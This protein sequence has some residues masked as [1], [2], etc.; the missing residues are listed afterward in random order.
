M[1]GLDYIQY[2]DDAVGYD[3]VGS[4][5]SGEVGQFLR[6]G[7]FAVKQQIYHFLEGRFL[8]QVMDVVA[9]VEQLT[10]FAIYE[11]GLGRVEIDLLESFDNLRRHGVSS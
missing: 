3:S 9:A 7:E 10:Y 11:T 2:L 1:A 4:Q 5:L 6:V 8:G